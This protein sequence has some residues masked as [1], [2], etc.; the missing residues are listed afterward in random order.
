MA[1][2]ESLRQWRRQRG[3]AGGVQGQDLRAVL[4][5]GWA[6]VSEDDLLGSLNAVAPVRR[7]RQVCNGMREDGGH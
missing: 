1:G 7:R 3:L 2:E 5:L 6:A 4:G